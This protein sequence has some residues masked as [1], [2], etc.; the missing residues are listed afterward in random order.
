MK[1]IVRK[2]LDE[3]EVEGDEVQLV[4]DN[5]DKFSLWQRPDGEVRLDCNGT[6]LIEPRATNLV[7]LRVCR[8]EPGKNDNTEGG[9]L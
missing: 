1:I 7:T 8:S 2:L 3:R 9:A 4:A 6:L 5:G